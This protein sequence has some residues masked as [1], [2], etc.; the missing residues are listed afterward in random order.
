MSASRK[1]KVSGMAVCPAWNL[2]CDYVLRP[3]QHQPTWVQPLAALLEPKP[4]AEGESQESIPPPQELV[5]VT[6]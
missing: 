6:S 1:P 5:M 2:D 3:R 4:V